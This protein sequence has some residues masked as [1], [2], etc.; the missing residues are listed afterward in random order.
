[1]QPSDTSE[2][3]AQQEIRK[4]KGKKIVEMMAFHRKLQETDPCTPLSV[5]KQMKPGDRDCFSYIDKVLIGTGQE[6]SKLK[7]YADMTPVGNMV[8]FFIQ[9][10]SPFDEG[11]FTVKQD[12]L[13]LCR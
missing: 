6:P 1:M 7:R 5:L 13:K 12:E 3:P 9:K 4:V 8:G 11:F 10:L 2:I